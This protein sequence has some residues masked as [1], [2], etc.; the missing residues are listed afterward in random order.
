MAVKKK[1]VIILLDEYDTPMQEAYVNGF[2]NELTAYIREFFNNTFKT[3]PSLE[4]GLMTGITRVSK[5]SIFSDINHL[6]VVTTTSDKYAT[7]F[8]VTQKE[9]LRALEEQRRT[10]EAK[11]IVQ[12]R[13]AGLT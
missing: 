3:N 10:E 5:E 8:G 4:R 6:N 12:T 13:Y 9:V 7:S 11:Q 2:W 1:K